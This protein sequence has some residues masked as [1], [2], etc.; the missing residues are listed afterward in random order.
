MIIDETLYKMALYAAQCCYH[1][2]PEES[3]V[4]RGITWEVLTVD[5]AVELLYELSRIYLAEKR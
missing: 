3:I 5:E 2:A 1:F 4:N